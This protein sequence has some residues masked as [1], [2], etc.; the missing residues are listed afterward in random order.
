MSDRNFGDFVTGLFIGGLVGAVVATL[1]TPYK[2]KEAQEE[3]N[4]LYEVGLDK[5]KELKSK[6]EEKLVELKHKTKEQV[7]ASLK[8]LEEKANS[9]ANRFNDLTNRGAKVL[10]EEEIV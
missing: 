3:L 9:I 2:G 10:I 5:S 4:H 7:K 8:V 1:T 6:S